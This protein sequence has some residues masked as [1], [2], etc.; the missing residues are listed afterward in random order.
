M[1]IYSESFNK[2]NGTGWAVDLSWDELYGQEKTISNS[3]TADE[4]GHIGSSNGEGRIASNV[5][6][7][8]QYMQV[9]LTELTHVGTSWSFELRLRVSSIQTSK[10][11]YAAV[12]AGHAD[13]V[14]AKVSFYKYVANTYSAIGAATTITMLTPT[15]VAYFEVSGTTLTAKVNNASVKTATDASLSAQRKGSLYIGWNDV[16][17]SLSVDSLQF[18]DLSAAI[19]A[20]NSDVPF[21]QANDR[22]QV[23]ACVKQGTST[24]AP[25]MRYWYANAPLWGDELAQD[26]SIPSYHG[27]D[28]NSNYTAGSLE[29]PYKFLKP[30]QEMQI[31]GVIVEF[32]PRPSAIVETLM[33]T[34]ITVGFYGRVECYGVPN[35]TRTVSSTT[36]TTLTSGTRASTDFSYSAKVTQQASE[37]WPNARSAYLPVRVD[38]RCRVARVILTDIHLVAISRVQLVGSILPIR[39]P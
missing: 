27:L 24:V 14:S 6:T 29:L 38:D 23:V 35:W 9:T 15:D 18:G 36:T 26:S 31:D 8:N 25:E 30:G 34:S 7:A 3:A 19:P 28:E 22:Y 4:T 2:T 37:T 10:N 17:D 12:F 5:D 39:N 21:L 20:R 16:G 1:T 11:Y 32:Y 13:T 33:T